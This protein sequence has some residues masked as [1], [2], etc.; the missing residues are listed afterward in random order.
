M[1]PW[2]TGLLLEA[3]AVGN[4]FTVTEVDADAVH[5]F[6]SVTVTVYDPAAANVTFGIVGFCKVDENPF[7]PVQL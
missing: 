2:Q 3:L 4:G 5:P 1:L 7:C 6:T